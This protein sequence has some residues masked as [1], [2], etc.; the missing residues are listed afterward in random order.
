MPNMYPPSSMPMTQAEMVEPDRFIG[1][2]IALPDDAA[3]EEML[4]T[5]KVD[6]ATN[7]MFLPVAFAIDEV[8]QFLYRDTPASGFGTET[9]TSKGRGVAYIAKSGMVTCDLKKMA[10]DI[11]SLQLRYSD[12]AELVT[13]QKT[14]DV[15]GFE[16]KDETVG[17]SRLLPTIPQDL[18]KR[19][20]GCALTL[21]GPSTVTF[22]G[23]TVGSDGS[24][25][26]TT[27]NVKVTLSGQPAP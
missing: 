11:A 27:V 24:A 5:G 25:L 20:S 23:P 26:G 13:V 19:F 17:P 10:C 2:T 7:P 15:A 21:P 12:G 4:T 8:R 22:S 1:W 3:L 9:T 18:T 16:A 14:S 6:L